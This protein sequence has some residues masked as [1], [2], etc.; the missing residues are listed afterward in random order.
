MAL[1]RVITIHQNKEEDCCLNTPGQGRNLKGIRNEELPPLA[2]LKRKATST[3]KHPVK[4]LKV[5]VTIDF[6]LEKILSQ[7]KKVL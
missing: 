2:L 3:M 1:N 7:I 6:T 5:D 4:I